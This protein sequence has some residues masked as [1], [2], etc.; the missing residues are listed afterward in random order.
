MLAQ[1]QKAQR[2]LLSGDDRWPTAPRRCGIAIIATGA[3]IPARASLSLPAAG[4]RTL[5]DP[6]AERVRRAKREAAGWHFWGNEA[7]RL[8]THEQSTAPAA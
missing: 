4:A 3:A 6:E 5:D 8:K 2:S 7:D 1:P